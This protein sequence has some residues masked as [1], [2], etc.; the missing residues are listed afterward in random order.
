MLD[1]ISLVAESSISVYSVQVQ[2]LKLCVVHEITDLLK[3]HSVSELLI[4]TQ[5]TFAVSN[6]GIED[7]YSLIAG[8]NWE[9]GDLCLRTR[10]N[11]KSS[12][13]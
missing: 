2:S 7:L 12:R 10:H 9:T 5:H 4:P 11:R 1:W 6:V 8:L 3:L 13:N